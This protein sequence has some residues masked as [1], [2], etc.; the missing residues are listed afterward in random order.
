MKERLIV[1]TGEFGVLGQAVAREF[2]SLGSHVCLLGRSDG[3]RLTDRLLR[4]GAT[5]LTGVDVADAAAAALAVRDIETRFDGIDVL[6]NAAGAFRWVKVEEGAEADWADLWRANFQTA[7][8]MSRAVLPVL[9]RTATAGRIINIGA[10]G[11][12][13]AGRGMGPYAASKAA[14]L[15]LTE[16]MAREQYH[17]AITVNAVLPTTIDTPANRR[18]MPKADVAR[19]VQPGALAKVIA[20]LASPEAQAITGAEITVRGGVF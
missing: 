8:V 17:H 19:W 5:A 12:L 18:D 11:A 15:K 9:Q 14:V 6:V 2:M 20:F 10:V 3:A 1:I 16:A 13:E 7:L 4:T